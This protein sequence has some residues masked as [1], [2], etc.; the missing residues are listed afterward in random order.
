MLKVRLAICDD[1]EVAA[2]AMEAI[3]ALH[4]FGV[5]L[6][7]ECFIDGHKLL[8]EAYRERYDILIMDIELSENKD[9]NGMSISR[10]IKE[11]YPETILIF[12][13]GHNYYRE[14]VQYEPFRFIGKPIID[15]NILINAVKAAI[16]K[17]KK[18]INPTYTY[19]I[20]G[21]DFVINQRDIIYIESYN[22]KITL[23]LIKDDAFE[24][25]GKLYQVEEEINK[26]F[27]KFVRISKS[28][29]VN[30]DFIQAVKK[31]K[32]IL[33]GKK[34]LLLSRKYVQEVRL[35]LEKSKKSAFHV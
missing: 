20:N 13:S 12:V 2:K 16:E 25:R 1:D 34:E 15:E 14:L 35:A 22:R 21:I 19:K 6:N 28:I 27:H 29:L 31:D 26:D 4:N 24:F 11:E 17:N 33:S 10:K 32:V 30:L 3:L 9:E 23:H 18:M 7:V 8:K 5:K